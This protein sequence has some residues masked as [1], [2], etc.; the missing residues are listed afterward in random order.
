MHGARGCVAVGGVAGAH[1]TSEHPVLVGLA[2]VGEGRVARGTVAVKAHKYTCPRGKRLI[3]VG[4]L[5][6]G[7]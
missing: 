4:Q 3:N 1:V 6:R 2:R 5:S 7:S